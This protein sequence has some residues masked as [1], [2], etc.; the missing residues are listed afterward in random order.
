MSESRRIQVVSRAVHIL[1][2]IGNSPHGL[3]LSQVSDTLCLAKQ[4]AYKIMATLVAEGLLA[5][6]SHPP[7]YMLTDLMSGL[8]KRQ[9]FWNQEFLVKASAAAYRIFRKC[10]KHLIIS[11]FT[12]GEVVGRL[13][14]D[15]QQPDVEVVSFTG[16]MSAYGTGLVFQAYMH[17]EQLQEFRHRHP[18]SANAVAAQYWNS[19]AAL[20]KAIERVRKEGY[21]ALLRSDIARLVIP[22]PRQ[23][24]GLWGAFT[25]L[26]AGFLGKETNSV[27]H[28]I[29]V[30]Q[31][32]IGNLVK[33]LH[34]PE[35]LAATGK[36]SGTYRPV[37]HGVRPTRPAA[38]KLHALA[39]HSQIGRLYTA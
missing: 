28:S 14:L 18:L 17:P 5:K 22:I 8:R 30:A 36:S 12:G 34:S 26:Q 24:G 4:T 10:G 23:S 33:S 19:Y 25:I 11:Q 16:R 35:R 1:E 31:Q 27:R 38:A 20:D 2:L 29:S 13:R 37:R 32:E 3:R 21:M 7:V 15:P 9:Q 39:P 6:S